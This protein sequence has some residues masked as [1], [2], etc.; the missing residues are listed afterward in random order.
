[1]PDPKRVLQ[2]TTRF[3]RTLKRYVSGNAQRKRCVEE[4]FRRMEAN[5]FDPRLK[6]HPLSGTLD[7]YHACSCGYDCRVVFE[8]QAGVKGIEKIVLIAVGTHEDVY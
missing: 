2:S 8:L 1:M 6:T 7:G 4:T 5:L 3:E